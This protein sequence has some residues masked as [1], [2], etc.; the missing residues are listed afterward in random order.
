MTFFSIITPTF[1]RASTLH[2]VYE[3]LMS[4]TFSDFEWIVVDDGSSDLTHQI[5]LSWKKNTKFKIEYIKKENG[6]KI[7]AIKEG[8]KYAT[9]ELTIIADSDDRFSKKTLSVFKEYYENIQKLDFQNFS[10]ISCLCKDSKTGKIVGDKYP[11]SPMI[12]DQI[13]ILYKYKVNGEKWGV[14]KTTVMKE[15]FFKIDLSNVTFIS[16][17]YFWYQIAKKYKTLFINI[18]LRTYYQ[19]SPNS[20]SRPFT[21]IKH[22]LG[23]FLSAEMILLC[24]Y[25]YYFK[26]IKRTSAIFFQMLYSSYSARISLKR[27]LYNKPVHL[28]IFIL[29]FLPTG[30]LIDIIRKIQY[31]KKTIT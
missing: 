13:E 10:G 8:L 17:S 20:L 29:L 12:S 26:N 1:N 22:P 2:R 25:G 16:E 7:S 24:T 23:V 27:L 28:Q 4:Q 19:N 15:I 14:I 21:T 6:G 5:I 30:K 31:R 11:T 18:P 3:S 9:A